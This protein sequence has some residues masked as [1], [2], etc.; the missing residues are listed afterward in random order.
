MRTLLAITLLYAA[1]ALA[2]EVGTCENGRAQAFLDVGNVRAAIYNN[3]TLFRRGP[4]NV[5]EVPKG[6]GVDAIY[7]SGIILGGMS[8]DRLRMAGTQYGP[9]EFWPGP[10]TEDGR[11]PE[12]CSAFDRIYDIRRSDLVEYEETDRAMQSLL[13]W[14]FH[15]GAPVKDGDGIPA[16]YNLEGGDR[17]AL[18]GDQMLWWVMNDLGNEHLETGTSSTRETRAGPALPVGVEVRAT[19]F[20]F[21]PTGDLEGIA[22]L[23]PS[24]V[25]LI[26][27][28]LSDATFYRYE[29]TYRGEA[30]LEDAWFGM[31][32]DPDLGNISDD[33]VGSDSLLDLGFV[34]NADAVD[35]GADGYGTPPPAL[36]YTLLSGPVLEPDGYDNDRDG[37]VDE[38]NERGGMS[39]F[40]AHE[41]NGAMNGNPE[42]G[43]DYYRYLRGYWRDGTPMTLSGNGYYGETPVRFMYPGNP[44]AFWSEENT[45]WTDV[46]PWPSD[47]RFWFSTGPFQMEPGETEEIVIG[48]LWSPGHDRHDSIAKLKRDTELVQEIFQTL[49]QPSLP[50]SSFEPPAAY[51]LV[52][53]HPNPFNDHT[54][55]AY[56]IPRQEHV[57]LTVVDVLGREVDTLV[58]AVQPPGRHEVEFRSGSLPAGVYFYEL[59]AGLV[60][61]AEMMVIAR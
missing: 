59:E 50:K 37:Q 25:P 34:Y 2:Q 10:L 5:Y 1:P 13:E 35:E 51:A 28:V 26:R 6:S 19:A 49:I 24:F 39:I 31:F 57:R 16:N 32:A 17:P 14:P 15:L 11:A 58:D 30:P 61:G 36:G 21:S 45:G 52:R 48:I 60:R 56:D 46:H 23:S 53:N 47:R 22:G 12:D 7:T 29:I 54:T 40:L 42:G 9:V 44:P 55:I 38:E 33:Y 20:G 8:G 41:N 4:D 43:D 27:G 3:G 18:L